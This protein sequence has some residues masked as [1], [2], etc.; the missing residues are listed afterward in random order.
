MKKNTI[1]LLSALLIFISSC[2]TQISSILKK[3]YGF[4]RE[5]SGGMKETKDDSNIE[6]NK[7]RYQFFIFQEY[8]SKKSIEINNIWIKKIQYDFK[9]E[10]ISTPYLLKEKEIIPSSKNTVVKIMIFDKKQ[11]SEISQPLQKIINE[12]ELVIEGSFGKKKFLRAV[13]KLSKLDP[14]YTE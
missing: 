2:N 5:V 1:L 4:E 8:S 6:K 11:N 7:P 13:Q 14:L 12:N 9:I 3:T 10:I